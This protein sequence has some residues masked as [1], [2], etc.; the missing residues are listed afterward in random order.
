MNHEKPEYILTTP[1]KL[2][3]SH[4]S[5]INHIQS[6]PEQK[7]LKI[8][9]PSS[10]QSR[11]LSTSRIRSQIYNAQGL[12][13]ILNRSYGVESMDIE[14]DNIIVNLNFADMFKKYI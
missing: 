4:Q 5:K 1:A 12:T 13:K 8:S 7:W 11:D 14:N 6:T 9:N 10:S 2:K 3:P